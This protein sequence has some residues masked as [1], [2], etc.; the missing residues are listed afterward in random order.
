MQ[1]A[2]ASGALQI[3][4]PQFDPLRRQW[5]IPLF[6]RIHRA[7]GSALAQVRCSLAL[8]LLMQHL[9]R[10][11][12][13]PGG[14]IGL[15]HAGLRWAAR[16]PPLPGANPNQVTPLSAALRRFIL[17][18]A[19]R[20]EFDFDS[21]LDGRHRL[22]CAR[23]IDGAP[24]FIQV[25]FA[26][27]DYLRA[28]RIMRWRL[29][30]VGL[31]MVTVV[32]AG[33]VMLQRRIFDLQ[34]AMADSLAKNEMLRQ[35]NMTD[36]LTGVANRRCFDQT[37]STEWRRCGRAGL[38][39]ALVMVDVDHFKK[40][41]DQYGHQAGDLCLAKVAE[42]LSQCLRRPHEIVAR[43]GG[44]EFAMILPH[45]SLEAALSLADK[46]RCAIL[47]LNIPHAASSCAPRVTVSLGVAAMLPDQSHSAVS[48]LAAADACLYLAKQGGR[49]RCCRQASDQGLPA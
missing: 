13:G 20:A 2:L 27:D 6:R 33:M 31:F 36:G 19:P 49:N 39:L 48:L 1:G 30:V 8:P 5:S 4:A 7:D 29:L 40:Y 18:G 46:A 43:Y 37:L 16:I 14:S 17:S 44:E 21:T 10:V 47:E 3:G 34:R 23:K 9:A 45:T 15:Y 26:D 24:Y 22:A 12:I 38:P 41:N 42:T 35:I 28:W 25:A 32:L 11:N